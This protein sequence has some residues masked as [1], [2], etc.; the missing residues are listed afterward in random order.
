MNEIR[1]RRGMTLNTEATHSAVYGEQQVESLDLIRRQLEGGRQ[2]IDDHRR[3]VDHDQRNS[4][5]QER[6]SLIR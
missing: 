2:L 4:D 3:D 5:I 6:G 1:K